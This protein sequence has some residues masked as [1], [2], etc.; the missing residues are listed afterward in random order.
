MSRINAT[1]S[2]LRRAVAKA[3]P[4]EV[5]VTPKMTWK[6]LRAFANG[7]VADKG[8]WGGAP[9]P[10]EGFDLIMEPRYPFKGIE[11]FYRKLASKG[12]DG[13]EILNRWY[14]YA[15]GC[16]I[17]IYREDGISRFA[18]WGNSSGARLNYWFNTLGIAAGHAWDMDVETRAVEKL[19]SLVTEH[20]LHCYQLTGS[21]L[22]TSKR[23]GVTY[24][25]RKLRPTVALRPNPRLGGMQAI[26]VLCMHPLG[27]YADTWAGAMCPT[28]DVVAHLMLMRGDEHRY[29]KKAN[30][31]PM[32]M[33]SAGI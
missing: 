13:I 2:L 27:Y 5:P 8:E 30:H 23:S 22:E 18:R 14:S 25:F 24:F 6:E 3:K 31:H 15:N 1:T 32:W 7:A 10:I 9:I 20:A 16:E 29:W 11:K 26:A 4:A 33:A 19:K 21:F 17:I 28:D 12:D